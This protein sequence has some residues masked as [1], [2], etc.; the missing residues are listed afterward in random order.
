MMPFTTPL[1]PPLQDM[2]HRGSTTR[3]GNHIH[4][5]QENKP[6]DQYDNVSY[7]LILKNGAT[8]VTIKIDAFPSADN[9]SECH[10][11]IRHLFT[12]LPFENT[13]AALAYLKDL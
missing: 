3:T 10:Y 9:P 4:L 7:D 13:A 5:L 8:E 6:I 2:Q 1:F 12:D 11:R